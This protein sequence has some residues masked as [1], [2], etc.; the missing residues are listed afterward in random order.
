LIHDFVSEPTSTWVVSLI[1]F[2]T[3]PTFLVSS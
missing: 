3:T 1:H 2:H